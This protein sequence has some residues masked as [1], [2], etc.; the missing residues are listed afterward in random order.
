[1]ELFDITRDNLDTW[2]ICC[3]NAKVKG[4]Y[5]AESKKTW[6]KER[7]DDGLVFKRLNARGK[8]F[9]EYIPAENAWCP[10]NAPGYMFINCFWVSG[11]FKGQGYGNKLLETCIADSKA[12]EKKG[13]AVLSS[14]KKMPFL[15]DPKYLAYKGFK[16]CDTANPYYELLYLPFENDAD[17]PTFKDCCKNGTINEEGIVLYYT[18]QCPHTEKYA[19]LVESIAH[20]NG[21]DFKLC[22]ITSKEQAQNAPAPFTTYSLFVDGTLVTNEILSEAKFLKLIKETNI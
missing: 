1:M 22:K 12:K 16:V 10:I 15:S 11:Q 2:D 14:K 8:V 6:M 9:I 20:D 4:D 3:A 13:L 17:K 5:R 19:L 18:N 21:A 7:F